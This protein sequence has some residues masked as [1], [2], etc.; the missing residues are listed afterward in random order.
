MVS[1]SNCTE[2][3]IYAQEMADKNGKNYIVVAEEARGNE[4][5]FSVTQDTYFEDFVEG[6]LIVQRRT[7]PHGFIH[8]S[9]HRCMG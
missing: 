5:P 8:W 3:G 7:L 9:T 2:A 6:V 1:F 4:K